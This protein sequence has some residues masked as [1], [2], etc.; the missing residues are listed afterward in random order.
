MT[1]LSGPRLLAITDV[2][3]CN[4]VDGVDTVVVLEKF[5]SA[6]ING[7]IQLMNDVHPKI[8]CPSS[9]DWEQGIVLA[10]ECFLDDRVSILASRPTEVETIVDTI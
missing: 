4:F 5:S 10:L 1:F 8:Q 2:V 7:L 6:I 9:L 3:S